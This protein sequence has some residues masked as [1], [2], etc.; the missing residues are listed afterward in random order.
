MVALIQ[1]IKAMQHS[2][3]KVLQGSGVAGVAG[4]CPSCVMAAESCAA[5]ELIVD[6]A[7]QPYLQ[8]RSKKTLELLV[9]GVLRISYQILYVSVLTTSSEQ[10]DWFGSEVGGIRDTRIQILGRKPKPMSCD[11]RDISNS[12]VVK[13]IDYCF[14]I[15]SK[16]VNSALSSWH[17]LKWMLVTS[18]WHTDLHTQIAVEKSLTT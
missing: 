2:T 7:I 15:F 6:D 4:V 1:S 10:K 16:V 12:R 5:G 17:T 8:K 18:C 14:E 3:A 13:K 9:A 11:K